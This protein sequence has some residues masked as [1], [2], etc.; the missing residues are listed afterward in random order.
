VFVNRCVNM[1]TRYKSLN[2][3]NDVTRSMIC[4]HVFKHF[5]PRLDQSGLITY[6]IRLVLMTSVLFFVSRYPFPFCPS[7]AVC[8]RVSPDSVNLFRSQILLY[9]RQW[10]VLRFFLQFFPVNSKFYRECV[11]IKGL[12]GSR[13]Y[14]VARGSEGNM[15]HPEKVVNFF[16]FRLFIS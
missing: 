3:S 16:D 2:S 6:L 14:F 12:I 15:S 10:S 7:S 4:I 11:V 13:R 8:T 1:N 9:Q 5:S